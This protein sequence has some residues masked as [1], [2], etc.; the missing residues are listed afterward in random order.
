[1]CNYLGCESG[2]AKDERHGPAARTQ[3]KG[4]VPQA[5]D[6]DVI[7]INVPLS[8]IL[9]KAGWTQETTFAR[10]YNKEI[11]LSSDTFQRAVLEIS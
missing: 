11:S 3:F 7:D 8:T 10:H 4:P 9:A 2:F 6:I 1:M 5:G